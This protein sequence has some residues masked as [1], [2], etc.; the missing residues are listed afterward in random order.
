MLARALSSPAPFSPRKNW[1]LI[2]KK[3]TKKN[4]KKRN[5]SANRSPEITSTAHLQPQIIVKHSYNRRRRHRTR[6]QFATRFHTFDDKYEKKTQKQK[7]KIKNKIKK[8]INR[9]SKWSKWF[10]FYFF[11][12]L[13]FHFNMF[14]FF[15]HL[16]FMPIWGYTINE[17]ISYTPHISTL[18]TVIIG[19][20][21]P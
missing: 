13:T 15:A 9:K 18:K 1:K 16:V 10:L 11:P 7:Q 19:W 20:W 5:S 12:F 17:Q 4:K 2:N 8:N 21:S 3:K 6:M 14:L